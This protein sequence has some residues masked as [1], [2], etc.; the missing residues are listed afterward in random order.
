[1]ADYLQPVELQI[2]PQGRV[3]IPASLR[4]AWQLKSGE[5]LLAHLE[6]DRLI[7]ERRAQVLQRV[8]ARFAGLRNCPSLADEL[9][10]ERRL[11]ANQENAP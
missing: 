8:K 6:E 3:V 7:L 10:A 9:I 1:M 11:A 2:G 4:R 5:I